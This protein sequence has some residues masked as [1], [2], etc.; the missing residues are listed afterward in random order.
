MR[1]RVTPPRLG[2]PGVRKWHRN[3]LDWTAVRARLRA[4]LDAVRD[5][6][7]GCL[8]QAGRVAGNYTPDVALRIRSSG[9]TL[10]MARTREAKV[11][12]NH[13]SAV[14][15][16]CALMLL[17]AC[18]A[19]SHDGAGNAPTPPRTDVSLPADGSPESKAPALA[20]ALPSG[21]ASSERNQLRSYSHT[22][23][24]ADVIATHAGQH[25]EEARAAPDLTISDIRSSQMEHTESQVE[26]RLNFVDLHLPQVEFAPLFDVIADVKNSTG[27]DRLVLLI[28]GQKAPKA[29]LELHGDTVPCDI[30]R[31]VDPR[32]DQVTIDIP[33]ECL[34]EPG[35]VRI[36]ILAR[37]YVHDPADTIAWDYALNK[38]SRLRNDADRFSPPIHAPG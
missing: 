15:V 10:D 21:A 7:A 13:G 33:R 37:A 4:A 8:H 30:G 23:R 26:L 11:P 31:S 12:K 32:K 28:F 6:K 19:T 22:D 9:G 24:T 17:M 38:G 1:S 3:G 20:P 16:L 14:P 5:I 35:W 27:D 2:S 18:G 25:Q 36:S 29:T 34:G